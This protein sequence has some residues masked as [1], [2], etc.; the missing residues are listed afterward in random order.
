LAID[1]EVFQEKLVETDPHTDQ[2]NEKPRSHMIPKGLTNLENIFNLRERFKGSKSAKTGISCPMYKTINLGTPKNPKNINLDK[3]IYKEE[4]KAYIKLF[5]QY[6]DVFAW[7]YQDIKTYDTSIIQHT[8]P[9]KHEMK[10]F[11]KNLRKYHP[12][13]EPLMCQELKKL[14]DDNIIF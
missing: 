2:L 7:S 9:L 6:Q 11:Q 10:L 12:S 13:L 5:K 3:T 4:M 14:L 1:D 8:I